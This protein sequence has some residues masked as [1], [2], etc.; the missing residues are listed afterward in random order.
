MKN[1]IKYTTILSFCFFALSCK[2]EPTEAI[3]AAEDPHLHES[4]N[5]V[6]LSAQQAK[7]IDLRLGAIE[8][9]QLTS[10]LRANG[11]LRVPNQNRA[12]ATPMMGGIVTAILV[13]SGNMV[14]KGQTIATIANP[15]FVVMQEEYLSV[16]AQNTLAQQDL[17]RQKTLHAENASS[18]K[19]LQTAQAHATSLAAKKAG[20][21]QQLAL[22]G[23][24]ANQLSADNLKKDI[25]VKSPVSGIV[26]HVMVNLGSYVDANLGIAEIVDNSQLHLDLSVYEKDLSKL[27]VG[28]IIHFTLTNIPGVAYDAEVYAI[29]NTFEPN[30]KA[31]AVHAHVVGQKEGL[32]DG[33]SIVAIVSLNDNL[34]DAV[35][36]EAIVNLNGQDYIF[37]AKEAPAHDHEGP[38]DHAVE[39]LYFERIPV[40][41]G[42]T[43][44]GY[45]QITL[46]KEIPKNAKIV[47]KGAFFVMAKL[48]NQG[49]AHAH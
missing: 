14:K 20:L 41:T 12:T 19:N 31:V 28:Q 47:T 32:I 8:Q 49:E 34:S 15:S 17:E 36:N 39:D 38:H 45:T 1:I 33:M 35:P 2:T 43:D 25:S 21:K 29:G 9:K 16:S 26:G 13:E 24:D 11:R 3:N 5:E 22:L 18:L 46:I 40:V 44:V 10:T 4:E 42:T 30:T 23:I 6:S 7:T 37:M 27:K 48:S